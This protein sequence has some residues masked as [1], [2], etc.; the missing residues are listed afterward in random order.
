MGTCLGISL[1]FIWMVLFRQKTVCLVNCALI[2]LHFNFKESVVV[3]VLTL[4]HPLFD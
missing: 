1:V 2:T 4:R 3:P